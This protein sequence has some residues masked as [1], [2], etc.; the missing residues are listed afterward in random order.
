MSRAQRS[1]FLTYMQPNEC[2]VLA[3]IHI[4]NRLVTNFPVNGRQAFCTPLLFFFFNFPSIPIEHSKPRNGE[5]CFPKAQRML[6]EAVKVKYSLNQE[7]NRCSENQIHSIH[8]CMHTVHRENVMGGL[9]SSSRHINTS[10][11]YYTPNLYLNCT[12]TPSA[13][14]HKCTLTWLRI[15]SLLCNKCSGRFAFIRERERQC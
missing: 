13:C 9:M 11:L 6:S 14:V 3:A 2:N 10:T 8:P 7:E 4:L 1:V 5:L 12:H 15:L